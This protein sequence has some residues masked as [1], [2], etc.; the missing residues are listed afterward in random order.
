MKLAYFINGHP[1]VSHTFIRREILAIER[2][3]Q[4][5]ARFALRGWDDVLFDPQDQ[6]EQKLTRYVL[7]GG[8]SG[9]LWATCAFAAKHPMRF[10]SG[11]RMAARMAW[12]GDR[13]W[14][15]H[16]VSLAEAVVLCRW[17]EADGIDH[18]HAHFGT[19][20]AEIVLLAKALHGPSYSFTVHGADEWDMPRQLKLCEKL[21]Y[22]E[23]VVTISSFTRAQMMR[24]ARPEDHDK[25]HVVH[26]GL[27][28]P[29]FDAALT[30][31]PDNRL[32]VCVGRLCVEKSQD[33]LVLALAELRKR[34]IDAQ[35]ELVGDG[36]L[37]PRI[38]ALVQRHGLQR[39]VTLTGWA[40]SA[41]V[42]DRL[43]AS[44]VMALPS[45]SE[46]LPVVIM[47]ALALGRPVIATYVAGIPELVRDGQEGFLLPAGDLNALVN[48]LERALTTPV[49]ELT[50]RASAA[51]DR[52]K[53]RHSI[54]IEAKKLMV[55]FAQVQTK[56]VST[57]AIRSATAS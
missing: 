43:R 4:S 31:V 35:L 56:Q 23:F 51:Y 13:T 40:S 41:A 8:L 55:L 53:A 19:N 32:I 1:K 22:A 37:R 54:D 26:C 46:G 25:I 28:A 38:E 47:E 12:H 50:R 36:P 21:Q 16:L 45:V 29:A 2:Q 27:D 3:G 7:R 10:A 6:H 11:L 5:V 57:E 42:F 15:H 17:C 20:S 48:A 30:P 44:R 18:V 34:N 52:V 49:D 24:W 39:Q 33:L 9:L 14:L